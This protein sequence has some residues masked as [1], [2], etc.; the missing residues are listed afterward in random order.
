MEEQSRVGGNRYGGGK[1]LR[2]TDIGKSFVHTKRILYRRNYKNGACH[3]IWYGVVTDRQDSKTKI[4][5]QH[6]TE[7]PGNSPDPPLFHYDSWGKDEK[8]NLYHSRYKIWVPRRIAYTQTHIELEA[9][10]AGRTVEEGGLGKYGHLYECVNLLWNYG[11][12][13]RIEWNPW[14][15]KL[16]EEACDNHFLAVAGC[17]SS[18]KSFGGAIFAIV[19]WLS[20]PQNT[21]C[22]VT[23]TSVSAARKR[24]WRSITQLWGWLPKE[25][26]DLGKIKP[27]LNMIHW[28][29]PDGS[30]ADDGASISLV[31]AE[32]RQE[33]SAVAKLVGLKNRLVILIAD[34]LCELSPAVLAASDNLESNEEFRMVALSNPRNH[35]DPF[36][37]F[38]EPVDGWASVDESCFEWQTKWGKAIRFDCLQSENFLTGEVVYKFMLTHSKIEKARQRLGENS[39]RFYRFYRGFHAA[40]GM[41]DILYTETD[42]RA[43]LK[44]TVDWGKNTPVKVAGMDTAQTAG[45]DKNVIVLGLFGRSKDGLHCLEY[46]DHLVLKENA[47]SAIP[48]TEQMVDQVADYLKKNDITPENFALDS[49]SNKAFAAWVSRKVGSRVLSVEFGGRASDK[50]VSASD[51]N[52][53]WKRFDRRTSELW[54]VGIELLRGGQWAGLRKF[55]DAISEMK[56]RRY[57]MKKGGDGE[58]LSVEEKKKMKLRT[59]RSPDNSD[60]WMVL[61]ELCRQRFHWVSE[62]RGINI[63]PPDDYEKMLRSLD[64]VGLSTQGIPDWQ[65]SYA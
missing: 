56:S 60:A 57:E 16:L 28:V 15:V 39:A 2:R 19:N 44:D 5:D 31:A 48:F 23:S 3:Q 6:I 63:L 51:R 18:S 21:L 12:K 22:L 11:G 47:T 55:S 65:P 26:K 43:Y 59:G 38:S 29:P 61:V 20:D 41:E 7:Y 35:D 42:F 33:A 52:P 53:A 10:R 25:W 17:S 37:L 64:M 58:R 54:G 4:V 34:E 45:G 30:I 36:G 14:L 8:G 46:Q 27:S 13:E 1:P 24:I 62:E 49:T 9:F 40:M 50:P 32:P